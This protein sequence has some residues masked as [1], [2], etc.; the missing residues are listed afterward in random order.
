M[1]ELINSRALFI[2]RKLGIT[3]YVDK[4]NMGDLQRDLLTGF[5]DMRVKPEDKTIIIPLPADCREQSL[6]SRVVLPIN[7]IAWHN[8]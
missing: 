6:P 4:Q 5:G 1:I 7:S 8:V 3:D 2:N